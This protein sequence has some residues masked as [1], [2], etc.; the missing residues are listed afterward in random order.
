MSAAAAAALLTLSGSGAYT[1]DPPYRYS[2]CAAVSDEDEG[3]EK[4]VYTVTF[5]DFDG[6]PF[7][8]IEVADGEEIDYSAIDTSRLTMNQGKDTQI[9]FHAWD[10]TPIT[11]DCDL[12]VQALKETGIIKMVSEP[13]RTEFY[14]TDGSID[15]RGLDVTI[16]IIT[17]NA[18]YDDDGNRIITEQTQTVNV[19]PICYSVPADLSEAFAD[20][21]T[22]TIS[23]YPKGSDIALTSYEITYME[24]LGDINSDGNINAVDASAALTHYASI[25]TGQGALLTDE[26]FNRADVNRDGIVNAVD[27]SRILTYYAME[28]TGQNVNWEKILYNDLK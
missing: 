18:E 10:K 9:R 13:T 2:V 1:V 20:G 4:N 24:N 11:T 16:T 19:T 26:Q 21:N 27:A 12:T 6:N 23:I 25:G 22:T 5:L 28:A 3:E 14:S 15:L 8:S 7:G 17:Q